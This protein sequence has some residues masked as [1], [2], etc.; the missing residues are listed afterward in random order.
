MKLIIALALLTSLGP[1][2]AADDSKPASDP[3]AGAFFPP[4]LILLAHDRIALTP[5]QLEA[6]RAEVA[7]TQSR[8]EE[9]RAK[10]EQETASLAAMAKPDRV[11]EAALAA[12]LDK[13]LDAERELKHLHIGLLA[14]IKNQLTPEQE[15]KLR[16]LAKDGFSQLEAEV[17]QRLTEKV[18]RV[19]EGAQ[20]WVASGRDP[21]VIARAMDEKVKPLMDAGKPLEAEAEVDRLLELIKSDVK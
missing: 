9:L 19:Q 6:F 18:E 15:A 21:S 12:Q 7:K 8:S 3:L 4:E 20:K 11:D 13:V 14:A 17:R 2:F 10:L 1:L 5:D 16:E